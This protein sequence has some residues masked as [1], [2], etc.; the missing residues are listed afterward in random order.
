VPARIGEKEVGRE[1]I[2]TTPQSIDQV[3][4]SIA[5]LEKILADY[6]NR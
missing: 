3:E 4:R 1:W 5:E 2:D 6:K